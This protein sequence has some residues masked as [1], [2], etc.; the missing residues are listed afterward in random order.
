M[1]RVFLDLETTGLSPKN[2]DR[3]CEIAAV[4]YD[5]YTPLPADTG[6]FQTYVNP[7]APV[8]ASF[9]THHLSDEFLSDKPLFKQVADDLAEF[10]RDT[11]VVAHNAVF[12]HE[13]LNMEF[14][15][16]NMPPL[17]QLASSIT[18][19]QIEFAKLGVSVRKNLDAMC[20]HYGISTEARRDR[21]SAIVDAELLAK[22]YMRMRTKQTNIDLSP[23]INAADLAAAPP[24]IRVIMATDAEVAAHEQTLQTQYEKSKVTPLYWQLAAADTA[25]ASADTA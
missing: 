15:L 14:R 8:G 3:V 1:K 11:H 4:A 23:T 18:C 22:A 25:D 17:E 19:S 20:E 7:Q 21:H 16:L 9:D 6:V 12:D 10:L 13:F 5:N 2:G 24:A